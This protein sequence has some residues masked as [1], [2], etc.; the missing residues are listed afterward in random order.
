MARRTVTATFAGGMISDE[1]KSGTAR[2]I[3]NFVPRPDGVIPVAPVGVISGKLDTIAN[4]GTSDV[5]NTD[6]A[7]GWSGG[8]VIHPKFGLV[9]LMDVNRLSAAP[10]SLADWPA[11]GSQFG[12]DGRM[13]DFVGNVFTRTLMRAKIPADATTAAFGAYASDATLFADMG[14]FAPLTPTSV[15]KSTA[16]DSLK[17]MTQRKP[18]SGIQWYVN[19]ENEVLLISRHA[20]VATPHTVYRYGGSTKTPPS[21]KRTFDANGSTLAVG[22]TTGWAAVAS[23]NVWTNEVIVGGPLTNTLDVGSYISIALGDALQSNHTPTGNFQAREFMVTARSGSSVFLD[24]KIFISAAGLYSRCMV[25]NTSRL[26][27]N[28]LSRTVKTVPWGSE[29]P[30]PIDNG[31]DADDWNPRGPN[32]ACYHQGRLFLMNG[33]RINWSATVDETHQ[34]TATGHFATA[35]DSTASQTAAT[36]NYG[37]EYKHTSLWDRNGFLNV[38]P[39]IGGDGVGL[40]SMGDELLIMKSGGMFRLVGGVSYDGASNSLDL[41]VISNTVGPE[42]SYSWAET[43]AGV[44][45][46]HNDKIWVYDGNEL[47]EISRGTIANTFSENVRS[48]RH[49]QGEKIITRVT[50]DAENVYFTPM[51]YQQTTGGTFESPM[52]QDSLRGASIYNRHLVLNLS[53]QKWFFISNREINT[54]AAVLTMKTTRGSRFARYWLNSWRRMPEILDRH[55]Y[56]EMVDI[57]NVFHEAGATAPLAFTTT[58][59]S[60]W[61]KRFISPSYGHLVSHPLMGMSNFNAIRPRAVMMKRTLATT[62]TEVQ[63]RSAAPSSFSDYTMNLSKIHVGDVEPSYAPG[64]DYQGTPMAWWAPLIDDENSYLEPGDPERKYS[65]GRRVAAQDDDDWQVRNHW[66]VAGSTSTAN[67]VGLVDKLVL[68]NIDSAMTAP[69]FHYSDSFLSKKTDANGNL[70]YES[71][72]LHG[73]QLEFDDVNNGADR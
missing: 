59:A 38:F 69:T 67:A 14:T 10:T 51:R 37:I 48:H 22:E 18:M 15:A 44:V 60:Q 17:P 35:A 5:L 8:G 33:S 52:T 63:N 41:Q 62:S 54:P 40:I 68:N 42:S 20:N 49:P 4:A 50:T 64:T 23:A 2:Y 19:T 71:N 45:F 73:L 9:A 11:N 56:V 28:Q 61:T 58:T 27:A 31:W 36:A 25:G 21:V 47:N 16:V 55:N 70:Y 43:P 72:I 57:D 39:S 34:M 13:I 32:G 12:L 26:Q 66:A 1:P 3:E 53:E 30:K 65:K 24:R 29:R 7:V 46:T 6:M